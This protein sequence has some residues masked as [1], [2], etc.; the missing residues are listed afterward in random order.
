MDTILATYEGH[1]I[2]SIYLYQ[3]EVYQKILSQL[4]EIEFEDETDASKKSLENSTLR[5]L[6]R[7]LKM[8]TMDLKSASNSKDA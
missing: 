2:F 3:F 4:N 1:T 5:R 8:P 7:I 6:H